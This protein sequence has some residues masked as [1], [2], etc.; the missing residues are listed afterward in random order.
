[1]YSVSLSEVEQEKM[2]AN[3]HAKVKDVYQWT[4]GDTDA[5]VSTLQMLTAIENRLEQLFQAIESLPPEKVERAERAKERERRQRLR[6]EKITM[7]KQLQEERIQKA[8]ERARAPIMKRV[9][10][11]RPHEHP[12][13]LAACIS[14]LSSHLSDAGEERGQAEEER[15]KRGKKGR[16]KN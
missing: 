16:R 15:K 8:L 3:L 14:A 9:R 4:L 5:K 10:Q 1:M 13:L 7:Q 11:E 12:R 2:L 6:E